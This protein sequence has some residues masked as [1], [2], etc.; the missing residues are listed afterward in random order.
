MPLTGCG[1]FILTIYI[2][3][4]QIHPVLVKR[5]Q[6]TVRPPVNGPK[7]PWSRVLSLPG[8]L[9][10]LLETPSRQHMPIYRPFHVFVDFI[11][12]RDH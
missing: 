12:S 8:A 4:C 6:C 3:T 2:V 5:V 11:L 1:L 10:G 7:D 9:G